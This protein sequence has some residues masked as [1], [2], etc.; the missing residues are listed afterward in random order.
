MDV[1]NLKCGQCGHINELPEDWSQ[2]VAFCVKCGHKIHVPRQQDAPGDEQA[3]L[4]EEGEVGFAEQARKSEGRK[5][6]VTCP[7]C[8]KTVSVSG[9]VAGRKARCKACDAPMAIP[10]PDDL[11]PVDLPRP[12]SGA[13]ETGLDLVAPG[14][15]PASAGPAMGP[16]ERDAMLDL[17]PEPIQEAVDDE[18][19]HEPL[20]VVIPLTQHETPPPRGPHTPHRR[21]TDLSADAAEAAA[22]IGGQV[23]SEAATAAAQAAAV[24][25]GQLVSAVKHFKAGRDAVLARRR[26]AERMR[27]MMWLALAMAACVALAAGAVVYWPVLFPKEQHFVDITDNPI[28]GGA[29]QLPGN[30]QDAGTRPT[31]GKAVAAGNGTKTKT[32]PQPPAVT[33]KCEVVGLV[34]K[35]FG[36][37]GYHPAALGS[38]YWKLTAELTAGKEPI[39]FQAMGKDVQLVFAGKA[40]DSLGVPNDS[41][42][43]PDLLPR[44]GRQETISLKPRQARKV[45]LL[46]EVPTGVSAGE[47]VIGKLRWPFKMA[48]G[49]ASIPPANLAGTFVESPPR[50]LKPML[51]DPVM[52]AIQAVGQQ[53]L[54][55]RA[56]GDG[57]EVAIPDAHVRGVASPAGRDVYAVALTY[58]QHKLAANLRFTE[59]G[60]TAILY[61]DARPF[62]QITYVNPAVPV[63]NVPTAV[64]AAGR[65]PQAP[66]TPGRD[67]RGSGRTYTPPK[68]EPQPKRDQPI[69]LPTGPSIFD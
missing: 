40:V 42:A 67:E 47:L 15:I 57:L 37:G 3:D 51:A 5:I 8:G 29:N 50:N 64:S 53:H 12:P 54:A 1:L 55:V 32:Q 68:P 65:E 38:I 34:T 31:T 30:G 63:P 24:E 62:H 45:T 66:P 20:E 39:E 52:A 14:E 46:F 19:T 41:R 11:E 49:P 26:R 35:T 27:S 43:G 7:Q 59:G 2:P 4:P 44:M 61:L 48:Q 6:S 13:K 36:P 25:A 56:K 23:D 9:R 22:Q 69:T 33:P 16:D 17:L 58:G 18:G 60:R 28:A 10:Y 21:A